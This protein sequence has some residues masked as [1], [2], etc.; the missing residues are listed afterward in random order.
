[1]IEP[2]PDAIG[3]QFVRE[4]LHK[5]RETN[6]TAPLI[7]PDANGIL[8]NSWIQPLLRRECLVAVVDANWLRADLAYACKRRQ[9]T[10]L[11]T[12]A[13]SRVLRPY[14]AEHVIREVEAH[15]DEW[16][17]QCDASPEDFWSRWVDEYLPFLN[18]IPHNSIPA[19][20]LAERERRRIDDLAAKDADDVPSAILSLALGAMFLSKDKQAFHAVYG[21][22]ADYGV[23]RSYLS[24]LMAGT[25]SSELGQ[26]LFS[27]YLLP[28]AASYGILQ[29]ARKLLS[30]APWLVLALGG[31]GILAALRTPRETYRAIGSG[32]YNVLSFLNEIHE[33][34]ASALERFGAAAPAIP[35]WNQF[36]EMSPAMLRLRAS[37]YT[38][39][40]S[41]QSLLSVRELVDEL[42]ALDIG[43]SA[44]MVRET[45][46]AHDCF[47]QPIAGKWKV[48]HTFSYR[49]ID[50]GT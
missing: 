1:M 6:R 40:R 46:R 3:A 44:T 4:R 38:L 21:P 33:P 35:T 31:A 11:I 32:L 24:A 25:D 7:K 14:C 45:L 34:Y 2:G 41:P 9:R 37:L 20:V 17:M 19:A 27:F 42:P 43:R 48:G 23:V 26:M 30:T 49:S 15:C 29:A 28:T 36:A 5:T 16:A 8:P 22:D 10:V 50:A 12:G 47:Q 39:A 13:N 18:V